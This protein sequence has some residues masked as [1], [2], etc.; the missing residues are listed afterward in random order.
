MSESQTDMP[1]LQLARDYIRLGGKRRAVIDD[2]IVST[3]DWEPEGSEAD[4][5]WNERIATLSADERKQVELYLPTINA[6]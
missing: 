4:T 3:R 5:F 1:L 6:T 2:N